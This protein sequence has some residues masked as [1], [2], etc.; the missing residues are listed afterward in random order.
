M[1]LKP[2]N[3]SPYLKVYAF[4]I[5][6]NVDSEGR[7]VMVGLQ[8]GLSLRSVF[9]NKVHYSITLWQKDRNVLADSTHFTFK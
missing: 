4:V 2:Q 8:V 7:G 3:T 9:Y 1:W 6:S 5:Q